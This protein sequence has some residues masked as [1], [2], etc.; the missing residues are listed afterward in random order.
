M[1][2]KLCSARTQCQHLSKCCLSLFQGPN[3]H[4]REPHQSQWS[5]VS[6]FFHSSISHRQ[7]DKVTGYRTC[8]EKA[9]AEFQ[10]MSRQRV[11]TII[12]KPPWAWTS[13][14]QR[15]T[16]ETCDPDDFKNASSSLLNSWNIGLAD[17]MWWTGV[18][19]AL[20]KLAKCP[21]DHK[22]VIVGWA[23]NG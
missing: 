11:L 14:Q 19:Q 5:W 20:A 9:S 3:V 10:D 15:K 18:H 23:V 21:R 4:K 22:A 1:N 12:L 6:T 7:R 17:A 16:T 2:K 13:S 8:S